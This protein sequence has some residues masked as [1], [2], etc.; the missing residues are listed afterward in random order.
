MLLKIPY[1]IPSTGLSIP[2]FY[3]QKPLAVSR[4]PLNAEARVCVWVSPCGIRSTKVALGQVFLRVLQFSPTISF[5]HGF[6]HTHIKNNSP[7]GSRTPS[8]QHLYLYY[9]P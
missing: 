2:F 6:L 3:T 8:I 5:Y 7:V 1:P 9:R 4:R